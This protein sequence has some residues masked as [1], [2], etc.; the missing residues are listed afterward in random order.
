MDTQSFIVERQQIIDRLQRRRSVST[1]DH[2]DEKRFLGLTWHSWFNLLFGSRFLGSSLISGIV[3]KLL[4][5]SAMPLLASFLSSRHNGV[6]EKKTSMWGHI[7]NF[8]P[9]FRKLKNR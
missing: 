3:P 6:Q 8:I 4:A 2:K 7:L 1:A 9:L 5:G